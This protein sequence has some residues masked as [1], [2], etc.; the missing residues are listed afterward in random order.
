M[1]R[2][3]AKSLLFVGLVGALATGCAAARGNYYLYDA[4]DVFL[5]AKAAGASEAVYEW[6]MATEFLMKAREEAGYSDYEYAETLAR[7]SIDWSR[8]AQ[9]AVEMG[10]TGREKAIEQMVEDAVDDV[11]EDLEDAIG[12][13]EDSSDN[14]IKID[15]Y[16]DIDDV[17][18]F[19]EEDE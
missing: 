4:T 7:E 1:I 2:Q 14:D 17:I 5:K 9:E 16:E 8:R 6:T 12:P 10:I 15:E 18:D 13:R 11:P 19:L 3:T